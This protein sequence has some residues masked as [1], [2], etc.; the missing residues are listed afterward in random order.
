M[1]VSALFLPLFLYVTLPILALIQKVDIIVHFLE[2]CLSSQCFSQYLRIIKK[3]IRV[4]KVGVIK[5]FNSY[6]DWNL[7]R[8]YHNFSNVWFGT[9]MNDTHEYAMYEQKY[10]CKCVLIHRHSLYI[11]SDAKMI[12]VY[13]FICLKFSFFYCDVLNIRMHIIGIPIQKCTGA[14]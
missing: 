1:F 3:Y 4:A 13:D 14:M 5:T 10:R 2:I 11:N 9:I 12:F 6:A 8:C 7:Y